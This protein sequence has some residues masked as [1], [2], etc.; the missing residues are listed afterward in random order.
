[1]LD[2]TLVRGVLVPA[3]MRLMGSL[4]WWAP[5]P[6]RRVHARFGLCASESAS[7]SGIGAEVSAPTFSS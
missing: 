1:V 3:L 5:G 4:N 6:L 7:G 2:A